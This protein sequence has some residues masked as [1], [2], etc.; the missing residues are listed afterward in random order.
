MRQDYLKF[1]IIQRILGS[2]PDTYCERYN[3]NIYCK[4]TDRIVMIK[5]SYY[6]IWINLPILVLPNLMRY[7]KS[8]IW[9]LTSTMITSLAIQLRMP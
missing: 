3:K 1:I 8:L 4:E 7:E 2:Y 5:F 6:P 9:H